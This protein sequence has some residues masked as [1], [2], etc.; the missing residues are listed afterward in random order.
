MIKLETIRMSLDHCEASLAR[1]LG[2]E[3]SLTIDQKQEVLKHLPRNVRDLDDYF[4]TL[5]VAV[6]GYRDLTKAVHE[7]GRELKPHQTR[8]VL[9]RLSK[10][11]PKVRRDL[12]MLGILSGSMLIE[13]GA[14]HEKGLHIDVN[15]ILKTL[16]ELETGIVAAVE[17]AKE[18]KAFNTEAFLVRTIKRRYSE[19]IGRAGT[20]RNCRC[21]KIA[22]LM[23]AYA[24]RPM[25]DWFHLY[26]DD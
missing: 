15:G 12:G 26:K 7:S 4:E 22:G 6:L 8:S 19:R 18:L 13:S 11:V 5:E 20:T 14:Y 24:G 1:V 21:Y 23:L 3:F 2:N 16:D 9:D 17:S 10:S 25:S